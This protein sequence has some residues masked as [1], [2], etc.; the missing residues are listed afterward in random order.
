MAA[1]S[2]LG[3]PTTLL[4]PDP[5]AAPHVLVTCTTPFAQVSRRRAGRVAISGEKNKA[6][7]HALVIRWEPGRLSSLR[8][9]SCREENRISLQAK[10]RRWAPSSGSKP[11]RR[12]KTER[13]APDQRSGVATLPLLKKRRSHRL[14]LPAARSSGRSRAAPGR[15]AFTY[16]G[17]PCL[18]PSRPSPELASE[19]APGEV[20]K[21]TNKFMVPQHCVLSRE[22]PLKKEEM[23]SGDFSMGP[24]EKGARL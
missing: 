11:H 13:N 19:A 17:G 5:R 15:P 14:K 22:Q 7:E 20:V 23:A 18:R 24:G 9:P 3:S 2:H 12:T 4:P 8:D 21:A 1:R 10:S 6:R 16:L